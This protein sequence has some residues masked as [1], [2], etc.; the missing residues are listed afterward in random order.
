[1]ERFNVFRIDVGEKHGTNRLAKLQGSTKLAP[2][3]QQ[4]LNDAIHKCIRKH[5]EHSGANITRIH[6]DLSFKKQTMNATAASK[7][8]TSFSMIHVEPSVYGWHQ[9]A[10]LA[11]RRI[12]FLRSPIST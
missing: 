1:M 6:H 11:V 3:Q 5:V 9:C 7:L 2:H 4:H 12:S 8:T 10:L